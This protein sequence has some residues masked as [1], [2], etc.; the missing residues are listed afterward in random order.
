MP[1]LTLFGPEF[2]KNC[3]KNS[4]RV[5]NFLNLFSVFRVYLCFFAPNLA[6]NLHRI[7][8]IQI[9]WF[10]VQNWHRISDM[11]QILFPKVQIVGK[12]LDQKIDRKESEKAQKFIILSSVN[13][14]LA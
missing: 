4:C 3:A 10:L 1:F 13:S 5:K 8:E 12:I 14:P 2:E 6:Q 11:H 7:S 9:F